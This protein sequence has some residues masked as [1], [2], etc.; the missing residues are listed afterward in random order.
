[1]SSLTDK[2]ATPIFH[3]ESNIFSE[4]VIG[5]IF[6]PTEGAEIHTTNDGS[7]PTL[8]SSVFSSG[9]GNRIQLD[10][11]LYNNKGI[12]QSWTIKA[13]AFKNG[14]INSE[15]ACATYTFKAPKPI[16][17]CDSDG[18]TLT[19]DLRTIILYT[20]N[21]SEPIPTSDKWLGQAKIKLNK[22]TT[23]KAKATRPNY[24]DSDTVTA[25]Y[26]KLTSTQAISTF[27]RLG[28][29]YSDD[30]VQALCECTPMDSEISDK[31]LKSA[32]YAATK[33]KRRVVT[34]KDIRN[35]LAEMRLPP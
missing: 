26:G 10:G 23:I 15:T 21:G 20:T 28:I 27:R 12:F 5:S 35:V 4:V 31:M 7:E 16:I 17:T 13:K 30:A 25:I 33:D 1:M 19:G 29:T 32:F 22:N 24:L 6:C 9:A 14:W 18:F 8:S 3:P 2:V 34:G 11:N